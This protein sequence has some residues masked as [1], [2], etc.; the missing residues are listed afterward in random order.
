MAPVALAHKLERQVYKLQTR[1][2]QASRRGDVKAVQRLQR[3]L[4]NLAD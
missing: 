4:L 3:L 2:Y 1:I